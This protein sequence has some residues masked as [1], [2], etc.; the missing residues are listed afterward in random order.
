MKVT[1][2]GDLFLANAAQDVHLIDLD[3][4]DGLTIN[5]AN[6]LAFESS[7]SYDVKRVQARRQVETRASSIVCSP[8]AGES[9][10]RPTV[11]RWC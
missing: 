7:L 6:V 3:G 1:G 2:H 9:P 11:C 5:G 4:S 10:S 8:G